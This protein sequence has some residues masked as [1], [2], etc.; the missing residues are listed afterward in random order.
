MKKFLAIALVLALMVVGCKK[1]EP[2]VKDSISLNTTSWT[3]P[4]EGESLTLTVTASGDFKGEPD[5]AW[6]TVSGAKVTVAENTAYESRSGKVTFTCGTASAVLT[7]NQDA[8]PKPKEYTALDGPANSYIVSEGGDYKIQA[9]VMG[10]GDKGLHSTFPITSTSISPASAKLLWE[11]AE[12]LITD[13]KLQDGYI[14]F[15]VANKDGNAVVAATDASDNILWSWHIWSA[16]APK[17]V[18]CGTWTLMDRN[19]GAIMASGEE[20]FG[21]YYQWGRKDPF[22]RVIAFDSGAGEGWYHPVVG[23]GDDAA[24]SDIHCVAYSIA[25]PNEY[26]ANSN[27]NDDWLIEA[28]QRYLWG[29]NWE[30]DGNIDF[31][32]FK[33]VFDPC[34]KGY[35]IA[36]PNCMAAGTGNEGAN[37]SRNS[38]NS[39]T[40]FNGKIFVPAA[41]F[42][43]IGGYGWYDA[44]GAGWGGLWECSTSWGNTENGFRLAGHNFDPRDNNARA[45]A[46]PVRCMK[47]AE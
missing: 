4:Y 33:S 8:A 19:L 7:V 30:V 39:Y 16:E 3:A 45:A 2:E 28:N 11:E 1:P 43:Y 13:V 5:V 23:S 10:N 46:H 27:R 21:L 44:D 26:I 20:S 47:Y 37:A 42:V 25:H 9:T 22:S 14:C 34:P 29:I 6:I 35:A 18:D 15:T 41:G 31:Q 32:P 40:I 12:G 36:T 38:D 24:S 17:D